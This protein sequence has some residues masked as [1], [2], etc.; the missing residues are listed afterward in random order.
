[1]R[2]LFVR[3]IVFAVFLLSLFNPHTL[4]GQVIGLEVDLSEAPKNIFHSKMTFP[5]KPGVMTLVYPKWIPGNH[6]PSGPIANFTGLRVEARGKGIPW[7][8]DD[9]DMYAF[10]IDV[11]ADVSEVT[12]WADTITIDGS[13]GASGAS[14]SSKLLDLNWNQV[15]IYQAESASDDVRVKPSIKLPPNWKFA[16]ALAQAQQQSDQVAFQEVSLTTLVD[17]PLIAG[18]H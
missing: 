16:T 6:R 8:R 18:E 10:H 7:R 4:M 11:P 1:M 12:I 9:V 15:L 14:A 2:G 3:I 13:A 17:S 5:A